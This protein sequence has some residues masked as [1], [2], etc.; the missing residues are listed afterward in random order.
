MESLELTDNAVNSCAFALGRLWPNIKNL[1]IQKQKAAELTQQSSF[2]KRKIKSTVIS[3]HDEHFVFPFSFVSFPK[4]LAKIQ[5]EF[6]LCFTFRYPSKH[7]RDKSKAGFFFNNSP[8]IP[9]VTASFYSGRR[10]SARLVAQA[11]E[12]LRFSLHRGWELPPPCF[13]GVGL[14]RL[15]PRPPKNRNLAKRGKKASRN[16]E[17]Y[18]RC[19]STMKPTPRRI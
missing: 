18:E 2:D 13:A 3:L 6:E 7:A 17:S 1:W 15:H 5:E 8:W 16:T 9:P 19:K 12:Q 14:C 10:C 4:S 11:E